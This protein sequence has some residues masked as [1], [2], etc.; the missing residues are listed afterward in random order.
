MPRGPGA[1]ARPQG[2]YVVDSTGQLVPQEEQEA[3]SGAM[4]GTP[5]RR[6][7]QQRAR[8]IIREGI[9]DVKT[10][11]K[12]IVAEIWLRRSYGRRASILR[13]PGGVLERR[14]VPRVRAR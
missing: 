12:Q 1:P 11:G 6:G 13:V 14:E 5:G 2:V 8:D 4:G 9:E 3:E 10:W 7:S